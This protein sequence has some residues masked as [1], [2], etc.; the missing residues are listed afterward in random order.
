MGLHK[1]L[2]IYKVAYDLLALAVELARNMNRDVRQPLGAKLRD[3]CLEVSVLIYRAN[4]AADK[5]PHL[6]ALVERLQVAE[7]LLRL[8]CDLRCI[9]RSQYAAAV[10]LTDSIGRQATGWRKSVAPAA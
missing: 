6:R 9:S 4:V 8:A 7:L 10:R 5:A 2:P 1:D 3:E